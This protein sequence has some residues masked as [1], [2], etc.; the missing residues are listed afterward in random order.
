MALHIIQDCVLVRL[1]SM[2]IIMET[3]VV[4]IHKSA[5]LFELQFMYI[6]EYSPRP[7]DDTSVESCNFNGFHALYRLRSH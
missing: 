3:N 4:P 6:G 7:V 5:L 2:I 1:N